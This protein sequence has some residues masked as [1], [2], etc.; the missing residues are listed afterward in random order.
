MGRRNRV[1]MRRANAADSWPPALIDARRIIFHP[2]STFDKGQDSPK[3][4]A[5]GRDRQEL[6]ESGSFRILTHPPIY[7]P[8]PSRM[9]FH[10]HG[11]AVD[12]GLRLLLPRRDQPDVARPRRDREHPRGRDRPGRLDDHPAA[13]QEQVPVR[14]EDH[15]QEGQGRSPGHGIRTYL[16]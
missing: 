14:G 10:D 2:L 15:R 3:A 7:R 8:L 12:R 5:S 6:P 4:G 9:G 16:H 1:N 13:G 11:A